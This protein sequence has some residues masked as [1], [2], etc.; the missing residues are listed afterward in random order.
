MSFFVP[1]R[2]E[3]ICCLILDRRYDA[4]WLCVGGG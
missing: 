2:D 4:N 1:L 3:G